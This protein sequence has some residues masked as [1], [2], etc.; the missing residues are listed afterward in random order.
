MRAKSKVIIFLLLFAALCQGR[1][2][3]TLRSGQS[4]TYQFSYPVSVT[5]GRVFTPY[6]WFLPGI[7]GFDPG[8]I[9]RLEMFESTPNEVPFCSVL[10][11]PQSIPTSTCYF[12][13]GC[14]GDFQGAVRV[15][16]SAGSI[17]LDGFTLAHAHGAGIDSQG[18]YLA[19]TF[20]ESVTLVPEPSTWA[21]LVFGLGLLLFL[22]RREAAK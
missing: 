7:S 6:C 22:R 9:V 1:S 21:L 18:N 8:E 4:Y 12:Q 11:D 17:Q 15:S 13:G 2:Q 14:W 20:N 19:S 3:I 5:P 10:Y 16:V